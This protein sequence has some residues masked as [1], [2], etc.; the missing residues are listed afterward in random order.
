MVPYSNLAISYLRFSNKIQERGD[1]IRRQTAAAAVVCKEH[2]LV[3]DE[4]LSCHDF[5]KSGYH[6][7]HI[8][9]GAF[10]LFL[11]AIAEG[12][13]PTRSTLIVE[14][15][16]RLSR[17]HP[18]RVLPIIDQILQAGIRIAT[19]NPTRFYTAE[20]MASN[21]YILY[22]IISHLMTGY[23]ESNK[24]STRVRDALTE[25]RKN[26][27]SGSI[28]TAKVP[29]WLRVIGDDPK[30][31]RTIE[32]I[33]D[34]VDIVRRMFRLADEGMGAPSIARLFNAEKVPYWKPGKPWIVSQITTT[35]KDR[36][37]LGIFQPRSDRKPV[38]EP[39]VGYYPPIIN[40]TLF[41]RV[42]VARVGR[43]KHHQGRQSH[44]TINLFR[45]IMFDAATGDSIGMFSFI[46]KRGPKKGTKRVCLVSRGKLATSGIYEVSFRY[47]LIEEV[48]INLFEELN[49]ADFSDAPRKDAAAL[50]DISAS[51][52][53]AGEKIEITKTKMKT[54]K[55]AVT[56]S[57][58]QDQL[59]ELQAER[60]SIREEYD[61]VRIRLASPVVQLISDAATLFTLLKS[62][63]EP[64]ALRVKIRSRLRQLVDRIHVLFWNEGKSFRL[65][66][67]EVV[68]PNGDY[69][70]MMTGYSMT[71]KPYPYIT[72]RGSERNQ[73]SPRKMHGFTPLPRI[74]SLASLPTEERKAEV[75]RVIK[76][77]TKDIQTLTDAIRNGKVL[78]EYNPEW[79]ETD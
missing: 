2:D 36:K 68:F 30:K 45:E 59:V 13:V 54:A 5:G 35:L 16:D 75:D 31:P 26:A 73:S 4:S 17:Q 39:L 53:L 72:G 7:D 1:S 33:K 22:E 11:A 79:L 20:D 61:R 29:S 74:N 38:G 51:L 24:K 58:Y 56:Y 19:T 3:L 37:V 27:A 47:D 78:R 62:S 44:E 77:H 64:D 8:K 14:K 34:R 18:M 32:T 49:P 23:E 76:E 40:Q 70:Q 65:A 42:Q 28:M 46:V 69:R 15:L 50:A 41:D 60:N 52:T 9:S 57:S 43:A 63:A 66:L 67:V 12:K 48:F 21:P 25:K 6:A 10:G 71:R 55:D